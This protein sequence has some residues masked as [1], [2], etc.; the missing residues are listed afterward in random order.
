MAI[1]PAKTRKLLII[2]D[3]HDICEVV[4]CAIESMLG[5]EVIKAESGLTGLKMAEDEQPDLILL[6]IMMPGLNGRDTLGHLRRAPQT[7][8]IPIVF[9]S[10]IVQNK[11]YNDL[12][13]LGPVAVFPKPFDPF[14]LA[15]QLAS[16]MAP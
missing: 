5:W 12:M 9:V 10:A 8:H 7:A 15:N 6:D 14:E 16:L 13:A 1:S 2:D 3:D 11:N 4:A